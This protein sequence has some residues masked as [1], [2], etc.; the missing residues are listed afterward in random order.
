MKYIEYEQYENNNPYRPSHSLPNRLIGNQYTADLICGHIGAGGGAR[1]WRQRICNLSF[2]R[3][4]DSTKSVSGTDSR[5]ARQGCY[6]PVGVPMSVQEY[7][8]RVADLPK[9]K[10]VKN[11]NIAYEDLWW[12]CQGGH[13]VGQASVGVG[14]PYIKFLRPD[15]PAS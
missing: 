8:A 4:P 11:P 2:E 15:E 6:E 9:N 5:A 13:C 10:Q 14:K 7:V 3:L 1:E 12:D